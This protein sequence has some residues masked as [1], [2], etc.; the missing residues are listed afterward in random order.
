M[1]FGDNLP[2]RPFMDVETKKLYHRGQLHNGVHEGQDIPL[3]VYLDIHSGPRITCRS[4]GT[5]I[6]AGDLIGNGVYHG[7]GRHCA[8]CINYPASIEAW[9]IQYC[10]KHKSK[11]HPTGLASVTLVHFPAAI[12]EYIQEIS[13]I[14]GKV[15]LRRIYPPSHSPS[16]GTY[17]AGLIARKDQVI[18]ALQCLPA[19]V[20]RSELVHELLEIQGQ[21]DGQV[22]YGN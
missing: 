20:D 9:E 10:M 11:K 4:C 14:Y 16:E 17:H 15:T 1:I 19:N 7:D 2:L 22:E 12:S 5:R 8:N 21:L 3:E 18:S 13:K 6:N